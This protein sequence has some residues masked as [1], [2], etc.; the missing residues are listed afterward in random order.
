M[1]LIV[2]AVVKI[3]FFFLFFFLMHVIVGEKE[4]TESKNI[5]FSLLFSFHFLKYK[6]SALYQPRVFAY[7]L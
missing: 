7:V 3:V 5:F 4:T 1:S 6:N 2:V